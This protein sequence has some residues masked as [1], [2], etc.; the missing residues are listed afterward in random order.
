MRI[1]TKS[2]KRQR[3]TRQ[4]SAELKI[5][6]VQHL[7][8]IT[9]NSALLFHCCTETVSVQS[10]C[11]STLDVTSAFNCNFGD[12]LKSAVFWRI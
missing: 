3:N 2:N 10:L 5:M 4:P 6:F 9:E 11:F 8:V 12:C 7:A 1:I